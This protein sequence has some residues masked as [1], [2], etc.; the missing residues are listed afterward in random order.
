MPEPAPI[1]EAADRWLRD[2]ALPLWSCAGF[3]A[4]GSSFIEALDLDRRP[5]PDLPRRLMVQAR[6]VAVFADAARTGIFPEGGAIAR[7]AAEA[8][9]A[10]YLAADGAPGW[11]FSVAADGRVIDPTRDLYAHAFA[12]FG[13]AATRRLAPS[14]RI[15]AAIDATLAFLDGP[16][17]DP[18][19]GGW[20]DALPRKDHLRR[21]NPHMHLFE[22]L[23]ALHEATGDA[24]ILK[25]CA[26]IDALA[27]RHFLNAAGALVEDFSDDWH[28][29]PAPGAGRVEAGHQFEWAWLFR[30]YEAASGVNRD[31]VVG[32]LLDSAVRSGLDPA[33]GRIC[34]EAGEDRNHPQ[35]CE[36]LLAA[37][38]SAEGAGRRAG[39]RLASGGAGGAR[40][41]HRRADRGAAPRPLL[42]AGAGRRLDRP[43]QC[44]RPSAEPAHAGEQPL[45]PLFRLPRARLSRNRRRSSRPRRLCAHFRALKVVSKARLAT[46]RSPQ[47]LVRPERPAQVPSGYWRLNFLSSSEP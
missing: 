13:L 7:A 33:T 15:D 3:D 32:S 22:A 4:A 31:A 46:K 2:R 12:L 6:Q 9:I 41:R 39:P 10:R 23:L 44:R 18:R 47:A 37:C 35:P 30:R 43:A 8:M 40:S 28:I 21:Q 16:F 26:E 25:R 38:R 45:S 20:W 27:R 36:P 42:S 1:R 5:L 17:R 34:D 11:V 14:Q 19:H 24:A 29:A